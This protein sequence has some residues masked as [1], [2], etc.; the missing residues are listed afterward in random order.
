MCSLVFPVSFWNIYRLL[1]AF[2][3]FPP[4]I[5][6][7]P[8]LI[9]CTC[10]SLS[11][12]CVVCYLHSSVLPSF[13]QFVSPFSPA[14]PSSVVSLCCTISSVIPWFLTLLCCSFLF[15]LQVPLSFSV[16]FCFASVG[17][18]KPLLCFTSYN[19]Y[20]FCYTLNSVWCIQL[21]P[22]PPVFLPTSDKNNQ[23]IKENLC[24]T[25]QDDVINLRFT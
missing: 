2:L 14:C 23:L 18:C 3:R 13:C 7:C 25:L 21:G 19:K 10:V 8:A 11:S 5:S 20:F 9:C 22:V 4:L 15:V 12:F 6:T 17:L 1:P 16:L 24:S